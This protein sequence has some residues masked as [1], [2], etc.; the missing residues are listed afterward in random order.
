MRRAFIALAIALLVVLAVFAALIINP[1]VGFLQNRL[2]AEIKASSGRDLAVTGNTSLQL[3]PSI[4]LR[5]EGATLSNPPGFGGE[6]FLHVGA[7]ELHADILTLL[8]GR[9]EIGRL[10]LTEPRL[11]LVIDKQGRGSWELPAARD[12]ASAGFPAIGELTVTRGTLTYRDERVPTAVTLTDVNARAER[13]ALDQPLATDFEFAWNKEKVTGK[14][15][16]ASLAALSGATPTR[17]ALA[18]SSARGAIEV[19]G[20]VTAAEALSFQ[21]KMKGT[22][23]S[24]RRL[25][26][27]F[28]MNLPGTEGFAK[29]ALEGDVKTDGKS[30]AFPK[31]RLVIDNTTAEG[32]LTLDLTGPR[33][34]LAGTLA[35]DEID[36][37]R[38]MPVAKPAL[39]RSAPEPAF[40]IEPVPLSASLKA[41]LRAAE[42]RGPRAAADALSQD[43]LT[44][45]A[46]VVPWSADPFDLAALKAV[47][48]ELDLSIRT[49]KYHKAAFAI[50]RLSLALK[51]AKLALESKE[52]ATHGGKI[53]AKAVLDT[54]P[55]VPTFAASMRLDNVELHGLMSDLGFEG[56]L[57]GKTTGEADLSGTGRSERELVSSLKGRVKARIGEGMVVGYDVKRV[58]ETWRLPP[59]DPKARTPFER[60]DADLKIDRGIAESNVMELAGPVVG[61]R[62]EGVAR[63]PTR[64]LDYNARVSFP[65]WWSIAVRIFG[66]FTQL[67]YDVDWWS[68]LFDRR[69][70]APT[71]MAVAEGLDLKD[72]ELAAMLESALQ[73]TEATPTRS[74]DDFD[75]DILR[76]LL[77][78][79]KG[80]R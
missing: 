25:A 68:T 33:P 32:T 69:T 10:T 22:T 52:L 50:P 46:P 15:T 73:K 75:P 47:D 12:H 65:N 42:A 55:A 57:A 78:S 56:Y 48:A 8:L 51:D 40:E 17:A 76:A 62:A 4:V 26:S 11:R 34:R 53:A 16:T 63:L 44:R 79:A 1:P 59:Y 29:A 43:L 13:V 35:A 28:D 64:Q 24:L 31:A 2:A 23:P 36:A 27:W 7:L 14:A 74:A 80:E 49:L 3:V 58:V 38:Y 77:K 60:I 61:A 20:E 66:P 72:P 45:A 39:T 18:L 19:D 6:P 71:R 30:I 5:M 41:Y 67:K 54:K 70:P 9:F 21:G 37:A